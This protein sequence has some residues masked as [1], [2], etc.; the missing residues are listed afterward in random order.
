MSVY[1]PQWSLLLCLDMAFCS[2]YEVRQALM[3][4]QHSKAQDEET[5]PGLDKE[6]MTEW[7]LHPGTVPA[8]AQRWSLC[9]SFAHH[10]YVYFLLSTLYSKVMI[11]VFMVLHCCNL[12][13]F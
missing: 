10:T 6:P 3:E 4:G 5:S 2:H 12:M 9:L 1:G 11:G 8:Q 7:P 13:N